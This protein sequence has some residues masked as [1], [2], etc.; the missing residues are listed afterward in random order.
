LKLIATPNPERTFT[1][2]MTETELRDLTS[3]GYHRA[4]CTHPTYLSLRDLADEVGV[5]GYQR[6]SA[7][8][9]G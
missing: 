8:I 4:V 2:E 3:L 9:C 1:V 6:R 7:I 5:T